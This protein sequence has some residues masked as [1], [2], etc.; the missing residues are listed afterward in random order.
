[1]NRIFLLA[2]LSCLSLPA[3]AAVN[4]WLDRYQIGPGE[5][6]QLTL[7]HDGQTDSQPDL[8]PVRQDF[9]ILG[10]SS[11]SS[12]QIVNGKMTAQSQLTLVLSP[13]HGGKLKIPALQWDGQSSPALNL[14]VSNSPAQQNS[15]NPAGAT[16]TDHVFLTATLDSKQPYVQAADTL[17]VRLYTD[18]PLYQAS[19]ELQPSNDVLVQQ[20]GQD[21]QGSTT[22]N[23]RPY[24]VVERKYLLFPQRSGHITLD[25]PVLSAQVQSGASGNPFGADPFFGNVFG[26][27]PFGG[28]LNATKPLRLRG[29]QLVMDVRPRPASGSGHN[30]LPARRVT[31]TETWQPDSGPIHVGDPITRH[32]HL[33]AQGLTASQLPDLSLLMPVPDGL[34]AYPDQAKLNTGVQGD[35]VVGSRDQDITLI[36]SRAGRYRI[37]ALHLSWWDTRRNEQRE[38]DLPERTLDV[39]PNSTSLSAATAPQDNGPGAVPET[40]P[41]KAAGTAPETSTTT[42]QTW[43]AASIVLALLWLG[44]VA[45]WWYSRRRGAGR[46]NSEGESQL[47]RPRLKVDASEARKAFRRAC[48]ENDAPAA[49][50]RLLEWARAAWPD[51]PPQGLRA[52]AERLDDAKLKTLLEQIDRACYAGGNWRGEALLE[53][54]AELPKATGRDIGAHHGLAGLYP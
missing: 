15:G 3:A 18:Q 48:R 46:Q 34:R 43:R 26:Q 29:E 21:S 53:Q 19:L 16:G 27:T 31:L 9:D 44:T 47:A 50:S 39:L 20:L 1:M 42:S 32:L 38:V 10:R 54:L 51:A 11:G 12:V 40:R 22:R 14:T 30:W 33:E 37:P 24:Q 8:S 41:L 49:R 45:A 52:L 25:G 28:M 36:A 4:A 35:G 5:T 13:R 23:G 7:Q 6:V 2:L 17:T